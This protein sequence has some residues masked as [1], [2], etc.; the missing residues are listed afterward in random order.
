MAAL[1][2]RGIQKRYRRKTVLR[3]ASMTA[4]A[5]TIVG[6]IGS[7]GSGK[8]TLLSILA[9]VTPADGGSFLWRGADL[10]RAPEQRQSVVGYV[11]QGSPLME[12]LTALDN[13]RLW[14]DAET[15]KR[16]LESGML[17][18]LGIPEFLRVRVSRLSGGMKKRL[19]IGCAIAR[20]P[21]LL[22]LDEPSTALD[23]V[24]KAELLEHLCALRAA[25]GTLIVATHDMQ[26]IALCD[27][28]W[29]L[30]DGV[31]APCG[32]GGG[33]ERLTELLR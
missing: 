15:L 27:A 28:L 20:R 32:S 24:C 9:G 19:V 30:R 8:S 21:E 16:E 29:L 6:L 13:L 22:L 26:E 33:M 23:L 25:G 11:P 18:T 31:L 2:L 10:L 7:N 1:E 14:Y 17:K 4:E 12:E 5:G 3:D